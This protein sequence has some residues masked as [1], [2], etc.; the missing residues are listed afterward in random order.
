MDDGKLSSGVKGDKRL[1]IRIVVVGVTANDSHMIAF[2]LV[3]VV[4]E[5]WNGGSD[6]VTLTSKERR[7]EIHGGC[8]SN[9]EI[10]TSM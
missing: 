8:W 10:N 9:T 6:K 2:R 1:L 5:C 4:C 3:T 7:R